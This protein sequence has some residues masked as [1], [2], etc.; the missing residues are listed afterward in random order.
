MQ[1]NY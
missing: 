1:N